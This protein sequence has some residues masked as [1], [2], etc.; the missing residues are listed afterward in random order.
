MWVQIAILVVSIALSMMMQPK[1]EK[2]KPQAMDEGD[3]PKTDEGEPQCVFF[4][5]CWTSDFQALSYGNQRTSAI[6]T[7][8]GK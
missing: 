3:L 7:K 5:D 8:S 4:G 6:K 2:P 1:A